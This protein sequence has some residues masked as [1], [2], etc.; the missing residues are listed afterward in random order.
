MVMKVSDIAGVFKEGAR[1]NR[2]KV[3]ITG[4]KSLPNMEFLCRSANQ[5]ASTLGEIS[6]PYQGR[7]YKIPG[8]RT[9]ED[10]TVTVYNDKDHAIRKQLEAWHREM[11]EYENN[12]SSAAMAS[13]MS[14][15]TVEQLDLNGSTIHSYTIGDC[16]PSEVGAIDLAWD[17]N[18]AVEEFTVTWKVQFINP[19]T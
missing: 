2:F 10:W 3:T 8:D 5:P 15:G 17:N 16:W 14:T 18:D 19:G 13:I 4:A 11:N 1:P 7:V 9:F 12:T 6:V